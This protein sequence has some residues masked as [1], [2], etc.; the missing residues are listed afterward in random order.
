MTRSPSAPALMANMDIATEVKG[1][2]QTAIT[3]STITIEVIRI[4]INTHQ[5]TGMATIVPAVRET[6]TTNRTVST[7]IKANQAGTMNTQGL[8]ALEFRME[9]ITAPL[10]LAMEITT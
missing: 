8:I 7:I 4:I 1:A 5:V 9:P 3:I 2:I 10:V 6:S